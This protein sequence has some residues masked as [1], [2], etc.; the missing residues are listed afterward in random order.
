MVINFII[1]MV[2]INGMILSDVYVGVYPHGKCL[3]IRCKT[4]EYRQARVGLMK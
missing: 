3:P 1:S 4:D 2:Y